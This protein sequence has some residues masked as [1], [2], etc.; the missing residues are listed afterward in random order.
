M[1]RRQLFSDP[2]FLAAADNSAA[3]VCALSCD[4]QLEYANRSAQAAIDKLRASAGRDG[5]S[6]PALWPKM[7]QPLA[8]EAPDVNAN[9]APSVP[10]PMAVDPAGGTAWSRRCSIP[11]RTR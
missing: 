11:S 3:F 4:G 5:P 7:A 10:V 2:F 9:S 6:W 8:R 1:G